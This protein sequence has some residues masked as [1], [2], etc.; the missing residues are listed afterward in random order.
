M[1]GEAGKGD[2]LRPGANLKSYWENYDN[3]FKKKD[4]TH[5]IKTTKEGDVFWESQY[6]YDIKFTALEDV[7]V[8]HSEH[9]SGGGGYVVRV[10]DKGGNQTAISQAFECGAYGLR[11]YKQPQ[12]TLDED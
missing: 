2:K 10:K 5:D 11:L 4:M 6:G 12:Y 9:F 1:N 3:I 7:R 8:V